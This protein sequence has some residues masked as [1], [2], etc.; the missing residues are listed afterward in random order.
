MA[1]FFVSL[2]L[3]LITIVSSFHKLQLK[4]NFKKIKSS[5]L[6]LIDTEEKLEIK[7][8]NNILLEFRDKLKDDNYSDAFKIL[9]V[10]MIIF[11]IFYYYYNFISE[12]QCYY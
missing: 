10:L 5:T 8:D 3:Y 7:I 2:F 12:I 9:K 1:K 11:I 6:F 4:S